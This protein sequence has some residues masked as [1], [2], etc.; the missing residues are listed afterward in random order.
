MS[1]NQYMDLFIEESEEHLQAVNT[2][3]LALEKDP[4]NL[5]IVNE[6]FRSAHTLKG[7]A[8][9][10]GFEDLTKLTHQMENVLDAI[11]NEQLKVTTDILNVVFDAVEF[12]EKMIIDISQGGDGKEDIIAIVSELE[13]VENGVADELAAPA[14]SLQEETTASPLNKD[15]VYDDYVQNV[16]IQAFEEGYFVYQASIT[17]REDCVLKRARIFMILEAL[18][19]KAEIIHALPS[20]EDLEEEKFD[21]DFTMTLTSKESTEELEETIGRISEVEKVTIQSL[22]E[23]D[24]APSEEPGQPSPSPAVDADAGTEEKVERPT[25]EESK[26]SKSSN[27]ASKSIRVN[28]DRIDQLMR[29][30][31]ELL[32]YRGRLE[33]LAKESDNKENIETLE[34]MTRVSNDLQN[35]ILS[36]RM[37]P[38][39]RVFNRFPRMVRSLAQEMGKHI[40]LKITGAD[41]ELDRTVVDQIGDPLVHLIRN[42]VDHGLELPDV[43][44]ERNKPATGVIQ[45]RAYHSGNHVMIEIEDDGAGIDRDKVVQKAV[46]SGLISKEEGE[47]LPNSE[48]YDLL[49]SSGLSTADQISNVSGRGVGLDVVKTTIESLGGAITV[50]ST[51]GEGS[52]FTIELPLTLSIILALLVK[53][54]EETYAISLSSIKE[55]TIIPKSSIRKVHEQKVVNFRDSVIPIISLRETFGFPEEEQEECPAVIVQ[56]GDKQAALLV[57]SLI[58]QEEIVIKSLGEFLTNVFAISGATILG[59]GKVALI[60]DSNALVS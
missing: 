7:M 47:Q 54:E 19:G 3:L 53:V 22:L 45:L 55:T 37:V 49:F 56:K 48:V 40:N 9:T 23:A 6:I 13:K 30:F 31:E 34:K 11:R 41:T 38:V 51:P 46:S 20:V 44:L 2:N 32:I 17:L 4:E 39:E 58:G 26:G 59:D 15:V 43:R 52:L 14:N 28:I 42:S 16:L 50:T 12:L 24:L 21:F 5:P 57:D 35:L 25:K 27:I 33:Q 18:E 60:I 36:M 29:S 8:A 10:M 1:T